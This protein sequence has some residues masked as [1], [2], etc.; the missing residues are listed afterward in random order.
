VQTRSPRPIGL[1]A[2]TVLE[3]T[4][5]Q[6]V[7]AAADAGYSHIGL[8]LIPATD[9]EIRHD[10]IGD[11]PLA[12]ETRARLDAT[13]VRALDVEIFRLEPDTRVTDYRA[14]LETA[15]LLGASN[16]LVAGNDPIEARFV[17]RFAAFCDLAGQ[18]G[19][20]ANVEPMPW[21]EVRDF[22]QGARLVAAADRPNAA[23]LIDAIHFDRGGSRVAEIASVPRTRLRYV[24]ICDAPAE[25]PT[26]TAGLLY[27]ARAHRLL[28]G[29]GGLDL[30]GLLRALPRELPISLEIPNDELARTMSG[31]ERARRALVATRRLLETLG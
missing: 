15:A 18:Y 25:R 20:V 31:T 10:F 6:M 16:A 3:L 11:T 12:R 9:T 8:R 23:V 28:P 19:I 24:Q 21:T 1:A 29:E 5:P 7:T 2:L 22:A 4:P 13:G 17:E 27:Q 26:D 30:A 14:A